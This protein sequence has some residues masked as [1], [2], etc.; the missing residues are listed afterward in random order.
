VCLAALAAPGEH[1]H[2]Q[3]T[4][5]F[6][7]RVD[8]QEV[9]GTFDDIVVATL[10]VGHRRKRLDGE[11]AHPLPDCDDPVVVAVRKQNTAVALD[12]PPRC[13]P[14]RP[15]RWTRARRPTSTILRTTELR[16][17]RGRPASVCPVAPGAARGDG[18]AGTRVGS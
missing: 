10:G 4:G 1:L 7:Q 12:R 15:R 11:P 9:A 2:Q 3:S 8:T 5:R 17:R 14:S 6:V 16:G 13:H 18:G